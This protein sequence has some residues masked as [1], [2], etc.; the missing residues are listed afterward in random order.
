MGYVGNC[1]SKEHYKNKC[2]EPVADSK[3]AK[4]PKKDVVPK[5]TESANAVESD[6]ESEVAFLVSYES[7]SDLMVLVILIGLMKLRRW[8]T[9]SQIGFLKGK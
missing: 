2:P 3:S 6:S 5:K 9:K 1:G 7:D 4:E 8:T